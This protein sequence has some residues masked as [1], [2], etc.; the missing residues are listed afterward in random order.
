[1]F[2]KLTNMLLSIILAISVVSLISLV[3]IT[4]LSIH[5]NKLKKILTLFVSLAAG[6]LL[7]DVFFH[8]LPEVVEEY[9]FSHELS[10]S[11]LGGIVVFFLV[12]TA[13]HWRHCHVPTDSSHSHSLATM[14]LIGDAAH[15]ILDGIIIASSFILSFPAGVAT[16]IAVA[17]H[18]IPQEIGDF[19]VLIHSGYSR[20][21]A[22]LLNFLISLTSFIGAFVV[23]YFG[24]ALSMVLPYAIG[25][26]AGGFLYIA[27]ADLIPEMHKSKKKSKYVSQIFVF[28]VG[29]L[30]MYFMAHE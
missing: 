22:L 6:T 15:N 29:I 26:S 4:T 2:I 7:G 5:T 8:L 1:M 23:Y 30:I 27:S 21:K 12:E 24:D 18:E 13:I 14:N 11:I 16:T 3:G 9:G 19:G 25:F 20:K 10:F 28:I 17:L